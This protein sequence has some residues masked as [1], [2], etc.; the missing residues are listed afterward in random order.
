MKRSKL[1][2]VLSGMICG[3]AVN[4]YCSTVTPEATHVDKRHPDQ[5]RYGNGI[6]WIGYVN[7]NMYNSGQ[8][9]HSLYTF[10][11][12]S[13]PGDAALESA[14]LNINIMYFVKYAQN[15][16]P[17]IPIDVNVYAIAQPWVPTEMSW[18]MADLATSWTTPGGTIGD[19]IDTVTV[20]PGHV[21]SFVSFDITG[22]VQDWIDNTSTN[23]GVLLMSDF[24]QSKSGLQIGS[25][26]Y[27]NEAVH[28]F[29]TLT[30]SSAPAVPEPATVV[31]TICGIAAAV[32][33]RR[34]G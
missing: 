10:D 13:L 9:M 5:I 4:A 17:Y 32:V 12:P 21:G 16:Q 26:D 15:G 24:D 8:E 14:T 31:L 11:T 28:P 29:V 30:Y 6:D 23:M 20:T 34:I 1:I 2:A 3:I 7:V 22:L 18:D 27:S 19:L 25:E 33:R